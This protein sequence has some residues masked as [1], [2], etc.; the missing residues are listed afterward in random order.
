[1]SGVVL[2]AR[3][4]EVSAKGNGHRTLLSQ[5]ILKRWLADHLVKM[6]DRRSKY[7]K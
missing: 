1:M 3:D 5:D 6:L 4:I 2:V 7:V